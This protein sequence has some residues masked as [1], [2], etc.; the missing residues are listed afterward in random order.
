M[1]IEEIQKIEWMKFLDRRRSCFIYF[2]Y[3]E[4]EFKYLPEIT[5]F[6]YKKHLYKW[7]G[8]K[9]VHYR[10]VSELAESPFELAEA[11]L[12]AV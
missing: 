2:P 5:G 7:S 6:G 1:T 9:G 8:D 11:P 3:I 4:A 10:S 12:G